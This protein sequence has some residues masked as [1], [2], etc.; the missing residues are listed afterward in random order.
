MNKLSPVVNCMDLLLNISKSHFSFSKM[1]IT[2]P[3][4]M[5]R[6][7]KI[8]EFLPHFFHPLFLWEFLAHSVIELRTQLQSQCSLRPYNLIP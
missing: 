6:V 8:I 1:E 7:Y 5:H 4:V 2:V 3:T